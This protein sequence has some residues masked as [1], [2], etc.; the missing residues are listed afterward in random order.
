MAIDQPSKINMLADH[1]TERH[2]L[3]L[4]VLRGKNEKDDDEDYMG[5]RLLPL[6]LFHLLGLNRGIHERLRQNYLDKKGGETRRHWARVIMDEAYLAKKDEGTSD[7]L[8]AD[9]QNLLK[10]KTTSLYHNF[11]DDFNGVVCATLIVVINYLF[12]TSFNPT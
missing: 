9:D 12:C 11:L 3:T 1:P 4:Y 5:S 7:I 6:E 2:D 8:S 10:Q